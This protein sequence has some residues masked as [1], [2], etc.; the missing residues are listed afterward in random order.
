MAQSAVRGP[1]YEVL[2][3]KRFCGE[4]RGWLA[5]WRPAS[6]RCGR[7][8]GREPRPRGSPSRASSSVSSVTSRAVD[9]QVARSQVGREPIPQLAATCD[10]DVDG[11]HPEQR[12]AAQDERET[13]S[14]QGRRH[15]RS[16]TRRPRPRPE[17]S[18]A[19][20]EASPPP[21]RRP[22]QPT[23]PIRAAARSCHLVARQDPDRA[24]PAKTFGL[25][26]LSGRCPHLVAAISEDRDRG[27]ADTTGRARHEH[28]PGRRLKPA[29]LE[30]DHG[31]RRGEP[32]SADRHR[33]ARREPA[34]AGDDPVSW[35]ALIFGVPAM[36]RTPSS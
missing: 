24:E 15:R 2:V 32:C 10:R 28:R 17:G 16:R 4:R 11:I 35:H 26:R 27:P 6:R 14:S 30:R 23:A 9:A 19:R 34:L 21:L 36:A 13:R 29:F 8:T 31:H 5:A 12:H 18:E 1:I 7:S 33:V 22:R 25:V 3:R 20:K